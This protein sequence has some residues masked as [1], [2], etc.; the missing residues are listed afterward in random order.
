MEEFKRYPNKREDM[1][2][3]ERECVVGRCTSVQHGGQ[4]AAAATMRAGQP[5]LAA[6][7]RW[8]CGM[9][10]RV[11]DSSGRTALHLAAS[12]GH[13]AVVRWLVRRA[14]AGIDVRDVES[15]Y[16]ALHRSIFYG[17]IHVAA[18]LIKVSDKQDTNHGIK[19]RP[20]S[21]NVC[22]HMTFFYYL[23][24]LFVLCGTWCLT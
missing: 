5:L 17:Q 23:Q 6:Y 15:G 13:G 14:D 12:C 19:S 3:I 11:T 21:G 2:G 4:L 10:G 16:T 24:R 20:I 1:N 9:C 18:D 7:M 22:T 8:L